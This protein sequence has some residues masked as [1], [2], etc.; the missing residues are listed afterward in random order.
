MSNPDSAGEVAGAPAAEGSVRCPCLSGN[1]YDACCGRL[2]CGDAA[3]ATAE[4][5]MRSRYAAFAVGDGA[6]LLRTWH[7]LTRPAALELDPAVRWTRLDIDRTVRGRMFDTEGVV[8]FTAYSRHNG[9]RTR[10][11]EISR[12]LK[13]SGAWLYLDA[14]G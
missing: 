9:R 1:T 4:E 13:V 7:P 8:E 6:Y 14:A 3:A 10:Q 11:H 5:L 12:F 2:H